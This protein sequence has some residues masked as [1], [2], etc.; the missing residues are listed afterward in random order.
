MGSLRSRF[1]SYRTTVLPAEPEPEEPEEPEQEDLDC[2]SLGEGSCADLLPGSNS[3]LITQLNLK[4]VGEDELPEEDN[5]S[6]H[7]EEKDTPGELSTEGSRDSPVTVCLT[8][9]DG[10]QSFINGTIPDLL[11]NGRPLSRRRTLGH[12]SET[13]NEVRREVE[14]SRRRSIKL[15]AQVDKLQESREG[16][17]W[18][19]HRERVT[20]EV[21][22]V[23]R[24]L[25]PLTVPESGTPEP[26]AGE[27]RLDA[28]L[29]QLQSVARELAISHTKQEVKCGKGKGEEDSAV[30]QQALWDRDE[31]I[32]KKKAMEDELLRSKTDM[33]T[34][35]NQ[36]LEAVQKRLEM[37][38]ELEAWKEDFQLILQQQV[39]AQQE[40]E[41]AQ[42]KPSRGL[43]LLR[44]T[45][46]PLQRPSNF[47]LPPP[48]PPTTNSNQIFMPRAA[49]SAAPA[50]STPPAAHSQWT[51]RDKLKRGRTS[52]PGE[53]A[54]GQESEFHM[55]D[56]FQVV[57]LD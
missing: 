22:S 17:G 40:A 48:T 37:S 3:I 6:T 15:K 2:D 32:E 24:L 39:R 57:S 36:L 51:W 7:S 46:K 30:L 55:G 53:D 13:L 19:Q 23:L 41:Q 14:L 5:V 33:M 52:R 9:E 21:L 18:S 4:D 11:K 27:N 42:K 49:V 12:V 54:A 43:G 28:A 29:A 25:R 47:P 44:R 26:L 38:L 8:G 45:N 34:L 10:N 56:G 16:P 50:P 20:D 35:N 31:A 1:T